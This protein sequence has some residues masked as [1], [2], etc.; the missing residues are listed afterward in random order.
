MKIT[1]LTERSKYAEPGP[2]ASQ[3]DRAQ[4]LQQMHRAGVDVSKGGFNLGKGQ[5]SGVDPEDLINVKSQDDAK[6]RSAKRDAQLAQ[7]DKENR[8]ANA[9]RDKENAEERRER[10]RQAKLDLKN[11]G[12]EQAE[13][14][15]QIDAMAA[16]DHQGK[17]DQ[18]KGYRR[19]ADG[20]VLRNP[21]YYKDKGD[22]RGKPSNALSRGIDSLKADPYYA[23]SK[24]YNDKVDQ[25]KNFL[26]QRIED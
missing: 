22:S 23:V 25:V 15:A 14:Q 19:S 8:K 24:Y 5:F 1:E 20:R 12:L 11:R 9:Q 7:Q 13:F 2:K 18:D 26:N 4:R 21:K 16:K 17:I 10:I 3:Y 6:E